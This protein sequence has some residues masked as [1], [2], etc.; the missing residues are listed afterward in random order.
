MQIPSPTAF[1]AF[2]WFL[3]VV[4]AL[5]TILAFLRGFI[6]AFFSLIGFLI[7]IL[8]ASWNFPLVAAHYTSVVSSVATAEILAFVSILVLVVL[9]FH[10]LSTVLYRTVSAIGLGFVDRFLGAVF[11]FFRGCL[12]GVAA[13]MAVAAF[14]PQSPYIKHSLLAPYFLS[15]AHAVSFVVPDRFQARISEGATHLLLQAPNSLKAHTFRPSE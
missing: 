4:L 1:N 11:G 2:D 12:F 5:S 8:V 10:L 7:G 3:F 13:M 9:L 14:T 6:R 15:A